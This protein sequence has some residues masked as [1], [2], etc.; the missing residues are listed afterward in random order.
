VRRSLVLLSLLPLSALADPL[1]A[2]VTL[3]HFN[4]QYVAGGMQGYPDGI[5]HDPQFYLSEA[6]V[7]DMIISQ[8]FAP[9]LDILLRH[10]AWHV[11][12]EMQGRMVE[13]LAERHSDTL[14]NLRTLAKR[15]QV[16]LVSLHYSDQLFLAYPRR[17]LER[18]IARNKAVFAAND[19]PLSTVDFNQEGQFNEGLLQVLHDNGYTIAVLASNLPA[20]EHGSYP[21]A[22]MTESGV[23]VAVSGGGVIGDMSVDWDG[24]GDGELIVTGGNSPYEGTD[25]FHTHDAG[26]SG[27][28]Q[29]FEDERTAFEQAGVQQL[30]ISEMVA[31]AHARG[32][33]APLP[34]L[35]DGDWRPTSTHNM[36]RW[37]GGLGGLYDLFTPTE[38]D[39]AV[40]TLNVQASMDV[41]AC[42]AVVAWAKDKPGA[43]ARAQA[44]DEAGQELALAQVSDSTGWTPWLGEVNYSLTHG[45]NAR[46]AALKCIDAPELRGHA[47]RTVDTQTGAV[48]DGQPLIPTLDGGVIDP[49]LDVKLDWT[50]ADGAA[51][52][53][54]TVTMVW[55]KLS[56]ERTELTVDASKGFGPHDR[57][58][59][60]TFPM[61]DGF[62]HIVYSPALE[63]DQQRDL[64]PDQFVDG[65]E[66]TLPT[67]NGLVALGPNHWLLKDT[68]QVHLAA[69]VRPKQHEVEL[70]DESIRADEPAHWRIEIL[71][72]SPQRALELANRL[73]VTPVLQY[74]L[75]PKQGCGCSE[76]PFAP[77]LALLLS[78]ALQ[79]ARAR[80]RGA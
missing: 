14:N 33:F 41:A 76:V 16:E 78:L 8:S 57:L 29:S 27:S 72:A 23:D 64:T 11:D 39:N 6:Q 35:T 38:K 56:D 20:F 44:L 50:D 65:L 25:N 55:K 63:E 69:L 12:L 31:Q 3:Y 42:E 60:L 51:D 61:D 36:L 75:T 46:D 19:L 74:P 28:L 45:Q 48:A 68:R 37:M 53:G 77:P 13:I 18:S 80:R 71:T 10:P 49:P 7:E 5:S 67:P 22:F 79:R 32:T 58:L 43:K 9:I 73:N 40:L 1:Q 24:P 52:A 59:S 4:I 21:S 54:R 66:H 62:D 47:L 30:T 15:G 2:H 26:S 17:D 70:R 34:P